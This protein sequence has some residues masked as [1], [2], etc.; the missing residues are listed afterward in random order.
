M[1]II[2]TIFEKNFLMAEEKILAIKD[3]VDWIQVDV[4]D[5]YFVDGKTFELEML[6]RVEETESSLFDI[7]LMVENPEKWINKCLFVGASRIIGHVE[8]IDKRSEFVDLIKKEGVETGLAFDID[9]NIDNDIDQDVDVVLLMGR[10]AGFGVYEFDEIV[11]EKIKKVVELRRK[12]GANWKIGVDGG[13]NI[14]NL[15]KLKEIGVDIAYCGSAVFNGD[16]NKN[17]ERLK[18]D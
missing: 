4:T 15:E 1:K 7:H 12:I 17:L 2:P 3:M 14:G 18:N 11:F 9:T 5:G 13:I 6:G 8:A 10:K 16:I